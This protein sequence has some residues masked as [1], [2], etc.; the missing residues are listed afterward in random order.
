MIDIM[1]INKQNFYTF[2]LL[3]ILTFS[4][5][6]FL[7]FDCNIAI[8]WLVTGPASCHG[9]QGHRSRGGWNVRRAVWFDLCGGA[10]VAGMVTVTSATHIHKV[11][12]WTIAFRW[13]TIF[14]LEISLRSILY[15][16]CYGIGQSSKM[17]WH[18]GYLYFGKQSRGCCGSGVELVLLMCWSAPCM[19]ATSVKKASAKCPKCKIVDCKMIINTALTTAP[20]CVMTKLSIKMKMK[21]KKRKR[22]MKYV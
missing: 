10:A 15:G 9:E 20:A 6:V 19:A 13:T 7:S 1:L 3:F 5:L 18:I 21:K 11:T 4:C 14:S 16:N 2:I 17:C 8:C 12:M 22:K